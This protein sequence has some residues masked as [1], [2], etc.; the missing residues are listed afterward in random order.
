VVWFQKS[1]ICCEKGG[2]AW[3]VRCVLVFDVDWLLV[4]LTTLSQ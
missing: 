3:L 4:T 1:M 2:D